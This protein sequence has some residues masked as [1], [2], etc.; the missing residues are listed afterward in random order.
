[1]RQMFR[2]Q[3][4]VQRMDL[5]PIAPAKSSPILLDLS[6]HGINITEENRSSTFLDVDGSG[7]GRRTAWAEKVANDNRSQMKITA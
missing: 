3:D 2:R 7:L 4:A 1:M 5:V 6:G